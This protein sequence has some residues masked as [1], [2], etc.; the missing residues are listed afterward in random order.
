MQVS[1]PDGTTHWWCDVAVDGQGVPHVVWCNSER[2]L[3]C[4]SRYD[5][6]SWTAPVSVNDTLL[7]GAPGWADPRIVID[8]AGLMHVCYTGVATGATGRDIF[9]ARNDGNGWTPSVRV[10]QDTLTNYNEWYSDLDADGP[11]N[12]WVAWDRQHE[13]SDYFRIH[14]SHYDGSAWSA[15]VRLD[16]DSAY[17]D[18][19]PDVWLDAAGNPWVVWTGITYGTN[20][21][22]AYFSRYVTEAVTDVV[23]SPARRRLVESAASVSKGTVDVVFS[24]PLA[25]RARLEV[26]DAMGRRTAV[27]LD[28]SVSAGRHRVQWQ[29]R[30]PAGIYVCRLEAL[31]EGETWKIMLVS[32]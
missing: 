20:E 30:I 13:G 9:Y 19:Y 3:I 10:T 7:V 12:V 28:E 31:G 11:D 15:E 2:G 14:A 17:Y 23:P 29:T 21:E 27:I 8:N 18:D 5:D 26:F 22:Y 6:S 16:G 24:L 4:Y 25:G 1:P 32:H